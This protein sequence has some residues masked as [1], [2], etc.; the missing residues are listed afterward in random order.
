MKKFALV[1][2]AG[3]VAPKHMKAIKEVGGMLVTAYD[4]S[5]S[6]GVID[7]YFPKSVFTTN[8]RKFIDSICTLEVDYLV[9]CTPNDSHYFW[10]DLALKIGIDVICE[11]PVVLTISQLDDL[12]VT[13]NL[14]GKKINTILQLR[15]ALDN[16][17]WGSNLST[18]DIE[19]FT[20]RGAWYHNSWKGDGARSGGLV[21]NIG[22]HLFD[23]VLWQFGSCNFMELDSSN[24]RQSTD[25]TIKGTLS[26][27][28]ADVT[29]TLSIST[30]LSPTRKFTVNNVVYD[31]SGKFD[32]LHTRSYRSI[33][34]GF[35]WTLQDCRPSIELVERMR[36]ILNK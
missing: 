9:V 11:K 28:A 26:L 22:I 8:L 16:P 34:D 5:D 4:H 31:L 21:T 30:Y 24:L 15:Y 19:Y 29:F 3:Y 35:G 2:A 32:D 7:K 10:C 33:L 23:Y 13:E 17:Q 1:G 12:N 36:K 18:I 27:S 14:T 6:V 20:P 25:D